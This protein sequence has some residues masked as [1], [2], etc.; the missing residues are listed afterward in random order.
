MQPTFAEKKIYSVSQLT[1]NIK[2]ILE[3][4][5]PFIWISGEISNFKSP[6]SGHY[7]FTLKDSQAQ[8]NAIMFRGQNRNLK[9]FPEDGMKITGFGRIS[10]YQPRGAYQIIMEYIEPD[11]IGALQIEFEQLKIKL[12]QEGLFDEIHKKEIPFLPEKIAL[13]T[14]PTGSV[15][16]DMIRV[17]HRRF[18]GVGIS[19]I[20]VKVQGDDS[21]EQIVDA[22]IW[23]NKLKNADVAILARGGGSLEDLQAFNSEDVARAIFK[24]NIPIISAIGH[25]TDYTISDFVADLRAPTPSVAAELAVAVKSDLFQ[26]QN[27]LAKQLSLRF[28]LYL[29]NHR[30]NIENL[31][32]RLIT[33]RKNLDNLKIRLDDFFLRLVLKFK[34]LIHQKREHLAWRTER[35][36]NVNPNTLV[37]SYRDILLKYN[38]NLK[39]LVVS[40]LNTKRLTLK[41]IDGRLQALNPSAVL[42]R[43]YSITRLLSDKSIILNSDDVSVGQLLEIILSKGSILCRVEKDKQNGKK[44]D[45]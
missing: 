31:T 25:E 7:Y 3:D 19:I 16:H 35:L 30:H 15:V 13:I 23:L 32:K 41:E 37:T 38:D 42:E 36:N 2:S 14:S 44:N 11:G 6:V 12:S 9:F 28:K 20:P 8:I 34:Q 33:P 22:I 43:G 1:E 24:S 45:V 10:V 26:Q 18:P 39:S 5:F 40:N 21:V 29:Q 4:N 17:L 27:M